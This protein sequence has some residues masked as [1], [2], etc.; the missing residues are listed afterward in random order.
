MQENRDHRQRQEDAKRQIDMVASDGRLLLVRNRNDLAT[1]ALLDAA[2]EAGRAAGIVDE[3]HLDQLAEFNPVDVGKSL[4][5]LDIAVDPGAALVCFTSG[6]TGNAKG[7]RRHYDTWL[8]SFALQRDLL[9]YDGDASVLVLGNLAHSMH[10]YGAMEALDRGIVPAIEKKFSP[11]R[12]L[13]QLRAGNGRLVYATPA[14]LN[15]LLAH[16]AAAGTRPAPDV[17]HILC[18]GAKLNEARLARLA[19]M[20]P[21]ARVVEFFGTTETS[22]ITIKSSGGPPGSV[23]P[24][25]PGV[26]LRVLDHAH[27]QL[28]AGVEGTIWVKSELLF[29]RYVIGD[30]PNTRWRDGYVTIGDRGYLDEA[31]NLFFTAR[32]GSMVT[33][34]GENVFLDHVESV[35]RTCIADGE[36]AIVPMEDHMRGTRLLAATDQELTPADVDRTLQTLRAAFGS[37]K[38]PRAL[39]TIADWPTLPSGKADRGKLA[40]KLAAR[41]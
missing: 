37:L 5:S 7:I 29:D 18:G 8:R 3:H 4:I 14:H 38:A 12:A 35:L 13:E 19:D 26:S 6:S 2:I 27:R 41:P 39:H 20:F 24:A 28:P 21:N 30:D 23:G 17:R 22:Y 36:V 10:L 33:I 31:G 11:R 40:A 32:E 15:L 25:C 34:A 16:A 9:R 1:V